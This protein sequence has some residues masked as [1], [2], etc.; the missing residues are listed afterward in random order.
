MNKIPFFPKTGY[1]EYTGRGAAGLWAVLKALEKYGFDV[2]MPSGICE[3]VPATV[4]YAGMKPVFC[5]VDPATGNSLLDHYKEA[6]TKNTIACIAVHN[7]GNPVDIRS[8]KKWADHRDIFLIE[9]VCNASGATIEGIYAGSFGNAAFYSFGYAKI[10]DAGA[11]GAFVVK[12]KT[13]FK[14]AVA[15]TEKLPKK[16]ESLTAAQKEFDASLRELRNKDLYH[17]IKDLY[18]RYMPYLI[19]RADPGIV[20]KI[21]NRCRL[22][23][24]NIK[25]RDKKSDMY[26]K[27][28]NHSDIEHL[29]QKQGSVCWR[30]SILVSEEIR[31]LILERLRK[32]GFHASAWY[33]PVHHLFNKNMKASEFPGAAQFGKRIINLWVDKDVSYDDIRDT[34][35][36]ITDLLTTEKH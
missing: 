5:D 20:G 25:E 34:S 3:I 13:L 6:V 7:Y 8:I 11:G 31:D 15:I 9:D 19:H 23:P 32:K 28:L 29:P 10:I 4:I 14:K 30:Y 27:M 33:P 1:F 36:V 17:S 12:S 2:L 18:T 24:D 16:S 35:R 26:S 21:S 22:F